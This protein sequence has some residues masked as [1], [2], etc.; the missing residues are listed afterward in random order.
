MSL[1][2]TIF[3][4]KISRFQEF[5]MIFCATLFG[6]ECKFSYFLHLRL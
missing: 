4:F 1:K 2:D 5:F 6:V 3:I